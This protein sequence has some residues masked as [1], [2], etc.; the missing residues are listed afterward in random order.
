MRTDSNEIEDGRLATY[1]ADG[2]SLLK[3]MDGVHWHVIFTY[4]DPDRLQTLVQLLNDAAIG[5][6]AW[7]RKEMKAEPTTVLACDD[8]PLFDK[9]AT[10][11]KHPTVT[12]RAIAYVAARRP[13]W[14]PLDQH[15]LYL[16][17]LPS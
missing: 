9:A 3:T 4:G 16:R 5:N 11:C 1:R 10:K 17:T 7:L 12:G 13:D 8:C 6:C 15:P 14:C 2:R